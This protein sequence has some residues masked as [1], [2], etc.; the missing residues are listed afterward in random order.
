MEQEAVG[1]SFHSTLQLSKRR[2]RLRH[3][4]HARNENTWREQ[5]I[6][7]AHEVHFFFFFFFQLKVPE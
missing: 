7:L 6:N 5:Q 2:A 3:F 4:G 1:Q